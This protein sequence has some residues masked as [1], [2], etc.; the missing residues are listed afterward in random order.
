MAGSFGFE[1]EHYEVS[2]KCGERIL[3]PRVREEKNEKLVIADGFSCREQ[4]E[5]LANHRALHTAE[6]AC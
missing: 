3:L 5:Q 2:Q 1:I 6:V 4:I